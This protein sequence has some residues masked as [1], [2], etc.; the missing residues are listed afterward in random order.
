[1]IG[2][3]LEMKSRNK[4][5][6]ESEQCPPHPCRRILEQ[7]HQWS[8]HSPAC[9]Y[10]SMR[11]FLQRSAALRGPGLLNLRLAPPSAV[12]SSEG[13]E[14]ERGGQYRGTEF[15]QYY[16]D[17]YSLADRY[18]VPP[19]PAPVSDAALRHTLIQ[20]HW[21]G[22]CALCIPP[23]TLFMEC[24]QPRTSPNKCR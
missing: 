12:M 22:R 4:A 5:H 8:T 7:R 9:S 10:I 16:W 17:V 1:M 20:L 11:A 15:I 2:F 18:G 23:V 24:V 14:R 19:I 3:H 6:Y 21:G 13:R